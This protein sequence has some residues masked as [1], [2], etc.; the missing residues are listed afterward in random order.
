M[1]CEKSC[2]ICERNGFDA[3][4]RCGDLADTDVVGG[5]EDAENAEEPKDKNDHD[6]GVED[7]FDFGVHGDELVD[8]PQQHTHQNN[9]HDETEQ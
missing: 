2:S 4:S 6:D 1:A 8:G 3:L 7:V 5:A 9:D